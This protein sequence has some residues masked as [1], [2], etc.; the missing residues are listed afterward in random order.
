MAEPTVRPLSPVELDGVNLQGVEVRREWNHI[1]I[2]ILCKVPAFAVIVENKID[3]G[4]H[5]SQLGRYEQIVSK[6]YPDLPRFCVL[7]TVDGD[8]PSDDRYVPYAYADLHRVLTRCQRT[9]AGA[10]GSDLVVVLE[11]Y[12]RL[13]GSRFMENE[14]ISELCRRIYKNHRQALE[15]I[16]QNA[17]T[18]TSGL[19]NDIADLTESDLRWKLVARRPGGVDFVPVEW[20]SVFPLIGKRKKFDQRCW[21]VLKF[22]VNDRR[23]T[24]EAAVW[25]TTDASLRS[26]VITRL[27]ARQDEFGFKLFSKKIAG[28]NFT[29]IGGKQVVSEWG[30]DEPDTAK[31]LEAVTLRLDVLESKLR[32]VTEAL[33]PIFEECT[34]TKQVLQ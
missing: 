24:S 20:P 23:C 7:L 14:K 28:D 17:G 31:V 10:I 11:H 6:S 18:P 3:S 22:R 12:L 29:E 33:T 32:G 15:L 27:T 21:V 16:Y 30:E 9:F 2:L 1:D 4:E 19:I 34:A 26:Q 5:G 13:I 25:P 8:S